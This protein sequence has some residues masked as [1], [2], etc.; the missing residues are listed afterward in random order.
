MGAQSHKISNPTH[1]GDFIPLSDTL[2]E[3]STSPYI[4]LL[5][6]PSYPCV[7]LDRP[8]NPRRYIYLQDL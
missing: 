7:H 2:H 8:F 5:P 1:I 4:C 3:K 6:T